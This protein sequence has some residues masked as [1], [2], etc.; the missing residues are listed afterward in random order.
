MSAQETFD[1]IEVEIREP[2]RVRLMATQKNRESADAYVKTAV[3]RRG[4]DEHYYMAVPAGIYKDGDV[5]R[6]T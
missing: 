5:R 1:V 6:A 2:H 3:I 4:C